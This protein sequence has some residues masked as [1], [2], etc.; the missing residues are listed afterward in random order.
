[1]PVTLSQT[2][3]ADSFSDYIALSAYQANTLKSRADIASGKASDTKL[4][5][6]F[7]PMPQNLSRITT[8]NYTTVETSFAY[9][10][11]KLAT[12]AGQRTGSGAGTI[13]STIQNLMNGAKGLMSQQSQG[14][15]GAV[16]KLGTTSIAGAGTRMLLG[17]LSAVDMLNSAASMAT[18]QAAVA[19]SNQE[20]MYAGSAERNFTL[21]YEF[22]AKSHLDVYGPTG[23]LSLL[24]QLEAYSFPKTFQDSISN[25]DLITVPPIWRMDHATVGSNGSVTIPEQSAPLAYL[26]QPKLLVLYNISASHDTTS[27]VIDDSGKT[28]PMRTQLTI[29]FKEIEPVVRADSGDGSEATYGEISAPKL[30]CRSEV[31]SLDTTN[32]NI[33][34]E[35]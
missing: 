19:M 26:G 27:V 7:V 11:Q 32:P 29:S 14:R 16:E 34:E 9:S 12:P 30:L 1:M 6:W 20:I 25:R 15:M 4:D 2:T 35:G 24:S 8:H 33:P 10:L 18:D 31:Y 28:Y 21:S 13:G 17:A 23:V 22:V 3:R 5:T